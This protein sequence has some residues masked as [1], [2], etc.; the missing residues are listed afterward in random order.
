MFSEHLFSLIFDQLAPVGWSAKIFR[1]VSM[2]Q[3]LIEL[4][5]TLNESELM[6]LYEFATQLF[7]Q[8]TPAIS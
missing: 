3:E 5:E 2:K 4:L 6:Y 1:S 7:S 8:D